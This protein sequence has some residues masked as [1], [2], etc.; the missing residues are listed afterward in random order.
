MT[1]LDPLIVDTNEGDDVQAFSWW[2]L[3]DIDR[4]GGYSERISFRWHF[5]LIPRG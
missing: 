3:L 5:G 1:P 2:I 4:Y